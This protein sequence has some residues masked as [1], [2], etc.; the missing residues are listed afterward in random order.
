MKRLVAI[1][2][3][4]VVF[5]AGC[6]PNNDNNTSSSQSATTQTEFEVKANGY[7]GELVLKVTADG[8]QIKDIAVVSSH[9]SSP[10]F[11]RAFPIIKKRIIDAQTPIVDSVSG[12]TFSSYAVKKAVAD[13]MKQSGKDFGDITITTGQT[14]DATKKLDDVTTDLVIVGGG[15]AGLTASIAAKDS[16]INNVILVE[17]L[18]ILSGNG[19]FDMN[20]FDL[21]NSKAQKEAGNEMTKEE[22][23]ESK[24][25]STD[26]D[27]RKQVWA[28]EEYNLDSWLRSKGI[29]L[30]YNYGGTNHMAEADAYAG[31]HIQEKL[32]ENV[33]KLGVD[34]RTGTKCTDLI[35]QDGKVTG[36]KVETRDGTY[37]INAKAVIVATGGFS[38]NKEL[39]AKYAPGA[40]VVATSNQMGATGDLIPVFEAND[41]K[42]AHMDVL[43][44]FKLII[45][46]RRDL[47]GAGD[48]F[49]LVNKNGDRFIDES[50]SGLEMAHAI[51]DQP[52]S[53]VFYIYDQRLYES[54]YRLQKHNTLGYHVK[55]DTLPELA[56]KLGINAEN[57]TKTFKT[58]NQAISGEGKDPFRETPFTTPMNSEGPYYGVQVESAIHMTKGGVV[59][60]ENAQVLTNSNTVVDGLY[61]A[62]EVTATTG[63]YSA[64]VVF[65][66]IAGEQA[67][68]YISAEAKA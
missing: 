28:D 22:F 7:G 53:K 43:S 30:N 10:V 8:T 5:L 15:P 20:F 9:E 64:S 66:K 52:D 42:M 38:H 14:H 13:A 36:I 45:K 29:E 27:A 62:G 44:I 21:Y 61:A 40:E 25:S 67:A 65:G 57:L 41:F 47:T 68:K 11:S 55:A 34:V 1:C 37:H 58:Y 51:L 4:F 39:L 2:L 23:L 35:M 12:A 6:S 63:A 17:K 48:G 18:D 31:E 24:K 19:K 16:G 60:N 54:A 46:N 56:E 33:N 49:I 26:S 32:E 3:A 50:K 59:A